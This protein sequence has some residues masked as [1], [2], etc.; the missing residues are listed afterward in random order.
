M[1]I[2]THQELS[3][4]RMRWFPAVALSILFFS[5]CAT[6]TAV[7]IV[8]TDSAITYVALDPSLERILHTQ[9]VIAHNDLSLV[10]SKL[11]V[12]VHFENRSNSAM[13]LYAQCFF[14]DASGKR[15]N[16]QT[17]RSI[18]RVPLHGTAVYNAVS[19]SDD[20]EKAEIHLSY[21]RTEQIRG[22]PK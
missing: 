11:K 5:S 6:R 16:D 22:V 14:L 3:Y 4:H 7:I 10:G 13:D 8:P 21:L 20:A 19:I 2:I 17:T 1:R 15:I 12:E 9:L 18:L